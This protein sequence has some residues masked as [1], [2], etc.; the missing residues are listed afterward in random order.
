ME[1]ANYFEKIK[2]SEIILTKFVYKDE[3]K[4]INNYLRNNTYFNY[5]MISISKI[6]IWNFIVTIILLN[7]NKILCE[8]YIILKINKSGRYKIL[9]NGDAKDTESN[10]YN[11]LKQ[12][13]TS[14]LINENPIDPSTV[15]YEFTQR[16]NTIKLYFEENKNTFQ[17]L[18]YGCSA[19][20]EIDASHLNTSNVTS[21]SGM[22]SH[23]TSLK[24]INLQ[25]IDTSKVKNMNELFHY[26]SSLASLDI[27]SFNTNNCLR[28]R[29]MFSFCSSLTSLNV[30]HFK[31][32]LLLDLAYTFEGCSNL[33]SLNVS[34]FDTKNVIFMDRTFA[35][36]SSLTSLDVSNFITSKNT[37]TAYMFEGCSLI[38]SLD[39]SNFDTSSVVNFQGMFLLCSS[40]IELNL[41][42]FNTEKALY[43][44]R[45]FEN[46]NNL[47]YL[48][49]DNFYTS[50]VTRMDKMF[51]NCSKLTSIN[52]PNFDTSNVKLM[53]QMFNGC[54]SLISLNLSIFD[55]S[56]VVNMSNMFNGCTDLISLNLNNFNTSNVEN[57][58][59]MFYECTSLES[60]DIG[61]II[62][63]K[64]KSIAEMF[65]RC[66]S[67]KSIDIK[68]FDT[69]NTTNFS[70]VFKDCIL[71]NSL[72]LSNFD[73]SQVNDIEYMFFNCPNLKYINIKNLIIN[74]DTK[75]EP[76]IDNS[77]VNPIICIDDELSLNKI[78]S[79]YQ[80][81]Y[82]LDSNNSIEYQNQTT[83]D[84]N[85][86]ISG[87]LLSKNSTKCYQICSYYFYYDENFHKY[88]CTEKFECPEPYDKLIDGKNECV[89]SCINT[90]ENKYEFENKLKKKCLIQCPEHYRL[91]KEI[92]NHCVPEC[93]ENNPFLSIE[94]FEC[95]ST[96]SM[97]QRQNK[98]CITDYINQEKNNDDNNIYDLV[99]NQIK[100]DLLN[101]FDESLVNGNIIHEKGI[102]IS[103]TKTKNENE[104]ND[105][106]NLG[107]CEERLKQNYNITEN[108]SLYML[109]LDV[110]QIGLR[111]PSVQYEIFYPLN[112]SKNL[113]KLDLSICSD[114]KME[115]IITINITNN[116]DKYNKSS[117]YY[118]DICYISDSDNDVDISLFDRKE[119]YINNNMGI[120]E[121]GCDFTLYNYETKK[122]VCSCEIKN[123]IP[124]MIN[125]Q[126]DKKSLLKSFV[127]I[128]NI[129]NIQLLKCY[130]IVFKKGNILKNIGC[131]IYAFLI[132][133]NLICSL[134]FITKDFK[135]LIRN[136]YKIKL[137][138]IYYNK[139]DII[140][141]HNLSK[142]KKNNK[143]IKNEKSS[144]R[145]FE[146]NINIK[147]KD[148]QMKKI[149]SLFYPPKKKFN[150]ISKI[151]KNITKPN[152]LKLNKNINKSINKSKSFFIKNKNNNDTKSRL[153][154]DEINH[155]TFNDALIQDKRPFC[156]YY[157]SLL[158]SNH[159][160]LFIFYSKDY[161]S[162]SIKSSI[163]IFNLAS[164]IS[165]NSLF[166]N[167]STMHK[168][169]VDHGKFDFLYQLPQIIYSTIISSVLNSLIVI[170]G[171]SQQNI[172]K[173]KNDKILS[174]DKNK[175]IDNLLKILRIKFLFYFIIDFLLLFLFWYYVTCFCG[176]YRNTQIHLLKDSLFS[177]ITSLISPFGYYIV[178][179]IF[180]VC[181]LKGKNKILY[182]FSKILQTI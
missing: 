84:D 96:C 14:I 169:Y 7:N 180:R 21:M 15:Y 134:Y 103:L 97:M 23:C 2:A 123:E 48:N 55:T 170:L 64:V 145:K 139:N 10:C 144:E 67:L 53:N 19:I 112:N 129:A 38:T 136:I 128:N 30:S 161:N 56:N 124:L 102:N 127:D 92:P 163:F 54:N 32:P 120:C 39:L 131:F 69:A 83:Y 118:N 155:L 51:L 43:M 60:L 81:Q 25:N 79:L 109:R 71:L 22:F 182:K 26:C 117:P 6:F 8:S 31:T 3:N 94:K 147:N 74:Q 119:E 108:E 140:S 157:S 168:I 44:F 151:K 42:N 58:E 126:I 29:K 110:E 18:F 116:I 80:C 138:I 47:T 50:S 113:V 158:N 93:S 89:K 106:I 152:K 59:R 77:L 104:R 167:D 73:F 99:I 90:K 49:I 78:I 153:N 122:A 143:Y 57:M 36:C 35:H 34:N 175:K 33:T 114:L 62:T 111:V 52:L 148:N 85:I 66:T 107:D 159:L 154:Y 28:M 24:S 87:C 95:T 86:I 171:L 173:I 46:C 72:D 179:A 132:I 172:L 40:L 115:R 68:N 63:S 166:F 20:S 165:I 12:K 135:N 101:N 162:K 150:N 76:V 105:Q 91:I 75:Y 141:I 176:I 1:Y 16:E 177:F 137:N 37:W 100:N 82:L 61:N 11:Y 142:G 133:L 4:I 160:I 45:M 65:T 149:N 17:C 98:L 13:P 164:S 121:D 9:F 41:S 130:K 146:N 27:S 181:S 125:I 178:P 88:F 5:K 174:K 70:N 156:K